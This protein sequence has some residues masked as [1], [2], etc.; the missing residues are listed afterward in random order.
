MLS[1]ISQWADRHTDKLDQYCEFDRRCKVLTGTDMVAH[2]ISM[3]IGP[4]HFPEI[5]VGR[6]ASSRTARCREGALTVCGGDVDT[7][8]LIVNRNVQ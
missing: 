1:H 5:Q 6:A 2:F 4:E 3:G 8:Q 7:G